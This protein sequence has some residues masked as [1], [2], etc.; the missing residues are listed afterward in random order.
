MKTEHIFCSVPDGAR[1]D[2]TRRRFLIKALNL[3]MRTGRRSLVGAQIVD[4]EAGCLMTFFE[5]TLTPIL[6]EL[7]MT[8]GS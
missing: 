5:S 7:I 2:Q 3:G 6:G 4:T 8:R 1:E